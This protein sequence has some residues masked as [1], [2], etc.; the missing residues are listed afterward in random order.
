M[1][2]M[3]NLQFMIEYDG[4]KIH[5]GIV[6]L[7]C[8]EHRRYP[9]GTGFCKFKTYTQIDTLPNRVYRVYRVNRIY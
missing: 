1:F 3:F 2:E 4:Q 6:K 5:S 7:I 9:P 8:T